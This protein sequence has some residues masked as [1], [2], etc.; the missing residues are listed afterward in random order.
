MNAWIGEDERKLQWIY[1]VHAR[2]SFVTCISLRS[3]F[4][5]KRQVPD[6]TFRS[7]ARLKIRR[8]R[9]LNHT[10]HKYPRVWRLENCQK[11]GQVVRLTLLVRSLSC[12]EAILEAQNSFDWRIL[13]SSETLTHWFWGSKLR[14]FSSGQPSL[15]RRYI[16]FKFCS[17]E[18]G[19]IFGQLG[20]E[21][22]RIPDIAKLHGQIQF[23]I[24]LTFK[25]FAFKFVPFNG[26]WSAWQARRT[27][28]RKSRQ[29]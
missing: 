7:S 10:N 15:A 8:S 14:F 18:W 2:T 25:L 20:G 26:G 17:N 13:C 9:F 16:S 28:E 21:N 4:N 11:F 22:I 24:Y 3:F 5:F 27:M 19:E 29:I 1:K 6:Q 12:P 23:N